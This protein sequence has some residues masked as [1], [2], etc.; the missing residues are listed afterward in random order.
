MFT[1]NTDDIINQFQSLI[2][3][4][5]EFYWPKILWALTI[6]VFWVIIAIWMHRLVKYLFRKFKIIDLIDK[7]S[8]KYEVED[9]N[10]KEKN[11][12][13]KV[14]KKL[15][16]KVKIDEISAKSVSYYIFLVFFRLAIIVIWI[17]EVEK[18]LWDLLAYL[19]SLFVWIIIW[20]FGIRFANFVYDV[21]YHTLSLSKQK[22]S[23]IIASWA[24]IIILFFTLMLVLNY[25]K[26]VDT[27]II[28]T[29]LVWFISMLTLAWGLAFWLGW[30]DIAHEILESFRK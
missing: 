18:F 6:L 27:F 14:Q 25:T 11:T 5:I 29:I 10:D 24:K 28:N 3:W 2:M 15:S 23:R 4:N 16:H 13:V 7:I 26:I 30:K 20:F 12:D 17:N 19:P 21:V 1:I 22:T 9:G 8:I